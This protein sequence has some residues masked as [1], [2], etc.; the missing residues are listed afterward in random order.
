MQIE[1]QEEYIEARIQLD[2]ANK[3]IDA[4]PATAKPVFQGIAELHAAVGSY[5]RR[6][7]LPALKR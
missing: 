7:G 6:H 5:E 1:T 2:A 4:A 3:K